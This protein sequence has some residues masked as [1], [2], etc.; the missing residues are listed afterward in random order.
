MAVG[1]VMKNHKN[2]SAV[3]FAAALLFPLNASR[4]QAMDLQHAR[5]KP[6][7]LP[8]CSNRSR[9]NFRM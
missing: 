8:R 1:D 9:T 7:S 2:L 6:A 4:A 5:A 3:A